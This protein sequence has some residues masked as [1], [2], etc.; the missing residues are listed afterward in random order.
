MVRFIAVADDEMMLSA[1]LEADLSNIKT[2][3][4]Y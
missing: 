2:R 1:G 3:Y 4:T